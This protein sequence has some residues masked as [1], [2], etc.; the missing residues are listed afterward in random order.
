MNRRYKEHSHTSD[1]KIREIIKYFS[2]D[3]TATDTSK[4]SNISRPTINKYFDRFR[5]IIFHSSLK[6]DNR[7]LLKTPYNNSAKKH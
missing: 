6:L 5:K 7:L 1:K 4:L 2:M 3:F